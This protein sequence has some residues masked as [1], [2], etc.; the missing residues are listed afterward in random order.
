MPNFPLFKIHFTLFSIYVVN[1]IRCD[2]LQFSSGLDNWT[3]TLLNVFLAIAVDNLGNAQALTAAE[4]RAEL[5]EQVHTGW[6]WRRQKG[7]GRRGQAPPA[8]L[9]RGQYFKLIKEYKKNQPVYGH[10]NALQLSISLH[11]RCSVTFKM[12]Q[13]HIRPGLRP[14]RTL[15]SS[16]TP[17]RLGPRA[18]RGGRTNVCPG[19]HRPSSRHCRVAPEKV[20]RWYFVTT[21]SRNTYYLI[22]KLHHGQ[23]GSGSTVVTMTTKSMGK[24]KFRPPVDLKPLKYWNQNWTEWLFTDTLS[25]TTDQRSPPYLRRVAMLYRYTR[26][27][28]ID[29]AFW[30]PVDLSATCPFPSVLSR[31]SPISRHLQTISTCRDGLKPGNF[32]GPVT[33]VTIMFCADGEGVSDGRQEG[34][35]WRQLVPDSRRY[36]LHPA[37]YHR[38]AWRHRLQRVRVPNKL[39]SILYILVRERSALATI[40]V[41]RRIVMWFCLSV[42][43]FLKM[44]LLRHFLSELDGILTQCCSAWCVYTLFMVLTDSRSGPYDVIAASE[45]N[46]FW[47]V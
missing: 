5:S 45:P 29:V 19:R 18:R 9:S 44:H 2:R 25:T 10:L 17:S 35:Q 13:I 39:Y 22:F 33:L 36:N 38:P 23:R 8:A 30:I 3:D 4:E 47:T 34:S 43:S 46:R 42:H 21:S 6:Q 32:L 31:T 20:S 27:W 15:G 12:H 24:R 11:Q 16:H 1:E 37:N 40:I 28:N 26:L 14:I 41:D 7:G